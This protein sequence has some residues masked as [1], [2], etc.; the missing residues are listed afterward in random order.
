MIE[1]AGYHLIKQDGILEGIQ[2]GIQQGVQQGQLISSREALMDMLIERFDIVPQHLLQSIN[3]LDNL[4]TL[5]VLRKNALKAPSIESFEN[6]MNRII[7]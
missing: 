5:K 7:Q 6:D 3:Q 4:L 2:Q 1:S